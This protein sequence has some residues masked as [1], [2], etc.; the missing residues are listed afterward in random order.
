MSD[1]VRP[2]GQQPTR[3]LCPWNSLGKNT[4][5]GCHLLLLE[6][7]YLYI[8]NDCMLTTFFLWSSFFRSLRVINKH[9]P[10]S[11]NSESIMKQVRQLGVLYQLQCSP[12]G[13]GSGDSESRSV[14]SDSSRPHGLYRPWNSPGQN[15]GVVSLSLLQGIFSTQRS[16]PGISRCRRIL[17][18]LSHKGSYL[19]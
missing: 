8:F 13:T 2:Y 9:T 3:L 19:N 6:W 10:H 7:A 4:G 17:Y 15:T 5:V 12:K 14:A 11:S 1:S 16:N 18:Q